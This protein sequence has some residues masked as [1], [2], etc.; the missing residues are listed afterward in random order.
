MPY[1]FDK[2]LNW[3]LVCRV[4]LNA[5]QV[6]DN[7]FAPIQPFTYAVDQRILMVGC[8]SNL[9]KPT[10]W[11]G[12]RVSKRLLILPSSTSQ[13]VASVQTERFNC[14]LGILTLIKFESDGPYP[15]LLSIDVPRWFKH[16][17]IE[18]WK[19]SGDDPEIIQ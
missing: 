8:R 6:A 17:Y 4:D 13:F 10:W 19:Y 18:V 15:Y 9:A 7:V 5:K 11:L 12:C 2:S 3:D 16:I 1:Q 14:Q